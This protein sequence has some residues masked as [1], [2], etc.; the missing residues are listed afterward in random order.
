MHK[1]Y[2]KYGSEFLYRYVLISDDASVADVLDNIATDCKEIL[3]R[4]GITKNLLWIT[5]CG[6]R[7][8]D[9]AAF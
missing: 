3:Y 6:P 5:A 8:A 4:K 7:E 1:E 2:N 9:E